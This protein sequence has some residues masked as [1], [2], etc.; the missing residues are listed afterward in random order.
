MSDREYKDWVEFYSLEPF[1]EERADYR[2]A[3]ICL[4]L[5]QLHGNKNAKL[6]N[7]LLFKQKEKYDEKQAV[8][9]LIAGLNALGEEDGK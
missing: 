3:L 9:A 7:F 2:N 1:G 5:A 4:V 8:A 6:D